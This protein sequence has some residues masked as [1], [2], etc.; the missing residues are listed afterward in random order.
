MRV[1]V[2][3]YKLKIISKIFYKCFWVYKRR[4]RGE[5]KSK[6]IFTKMWDGRGKVF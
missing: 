6:K 5:L 3:L 1:L 2:L 4:W